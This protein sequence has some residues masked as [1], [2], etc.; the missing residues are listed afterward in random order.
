MAIFTPTVRIIVD[1]EPVDAATTNGPISDLTQRTDWLYQ[2]FQQLLAGSQLVLRAQPLAPGLVDGTPV[3]YDDTAAVFKAAQAAV[4][5]DNL[6]L[7]ADS[8][9]WQGVLANVSGTVGDVVINGVFEMA[10]ASWAAIFEDGVFAAGNI[11]LSAV[12]AGKVT[13][14]SNTTGVYIGNL[15]TDGTLNIRPGGVSAFLQHVHYERELSGN[16]AGT[17]VDPAFNAVQ[18]VTAPNPA[19]VGWLPANP[20]YFPGFVVGV[21][22]PTGA[23]FGYNIQ[24]SSETALREIFPVV[25]ADNAQ[26]SQGG[27]I[28]P[29]TR[30]VTNNFGIWW[31]D[32]AYGTAPWPV[33]YNATSTSDPITLWTTRLIAEVDLVDTLVNAVISALGSGEIDSIAVARIFSGNQTDL[34][35]TGTE[36]NLANGFQGTV[37]ITNRGVTSIRGGRGISFVGTSGDV[38]NGLRGT[39]D[40]TVDLELAASHLYTNLT[41]P[42]DKLVPVTTNGVSAGTPINLY[43]HRLGATVATD[44]VDFVV[45]GGDDLEAATDYYVIPVIIACVD[46]PSGVVTARQ[47]GINFYRYANGNPASTTGLQLQTNFFIN[48]GTPGTIQNVVVGPF[49]A[50]VIRQNQTS[51]VRIVNSTGGSPL[52]A[53]TLRIVSVRYRLQ[54]V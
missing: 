54:K 13:L 52:T 12:T 44:Y 9:Y 45:T 24:Q 37:T 34:E 46:S 43:G 22:I 29:S 26:F 47:V 40:A 5:T 48:T 42:G 21:Q 27:L 6:N 51:I 23:K 36:G 35:I 8:S 10:P 18:V 31:M 33:D 39:V 30:V 38:T 3:Y 11:Y 17:V 49:P 32:D 20:T 4:D 1:G 15:R 7:A 50:A 19:L 25:P 14:A 53:D 16:P 2:Q 28:L 41:V